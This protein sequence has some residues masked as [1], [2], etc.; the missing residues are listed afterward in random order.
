MGVLS[1]PFVVTVAGPP[2]APG[3]PFVVVAAVAYLVQTDSVGELPLVYTG[4]KVRAAANNLR[5]TRRTPMRE[6]EFTLAPIL[7][8]AYQ[9]MVAAT[10]NDAVVAFTG[11]AISNAVLQAMVEITA[12]PYVPHRLG[13]LRRPTIRVQQAG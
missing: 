4:Q 6:F 9:A 2:P 3:D 13:F 8:A 11:T 5:S 1:D 12:A 7:E 10:L